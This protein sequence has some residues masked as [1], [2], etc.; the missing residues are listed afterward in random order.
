MKM[1][2]TFQEAEALRCADP[3]LDLASAIRAARLAHRKID[4]Q[5]LRST[6]E[7]IESSLCKL[8]RPES[9]EEWLARSTPLPPTEMEPAPPGGSWSKAF[10]KP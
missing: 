6:F 2:N 9:I 10:S 5:I 8:G 4:Q 3:N 1:V 7:A